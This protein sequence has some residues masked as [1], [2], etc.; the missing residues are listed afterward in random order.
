MIGTIEVL[1]QNS[2]FLVVKTKFQLSASAVSAGYAFSLYFLVRED[3]ILRK[4]SP[5]SEFGGSRGTLEGF[6][7]GFMARGQRI[8]V[9]EG[10]MPFPYK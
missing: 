7:W 3:S 4:M 1:I 6:L 5:F 8:S 10:E 2:K 9:G